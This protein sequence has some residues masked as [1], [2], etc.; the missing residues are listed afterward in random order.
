MKTNGRTTAVLGAAIALA[1]AFTGGVAHAAPTPETP[2]GDAKTAVQAAMSEKDFVA[3]AMRVGGLSEAAARDAY[4]DPGHRALTVPVEVVA[5]DTAVAAA[6][7]GT[8][9][10]LARA[11]SCRLTAK[12]DFRNGL[13]H[14]LFRYTVHKSWEG[15]GTK[16]RNVRHEV[17]HSTTALGRAGGWKFNKTVDSVNEYRKWNGITNG[18]HYSSRTGQWKASPL[19][20]RNLQVRIMSRADGSWTTHEKSGKCW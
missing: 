8:P 4:R 5:E 2:A 19:E 11:G 1:A 12:R 6:S 7:T 3:A 14:R 18:R 20:K 17:G 9:S 15:T 16:V 13:G 10:A